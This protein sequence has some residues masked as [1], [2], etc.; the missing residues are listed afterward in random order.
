VNDIC[1]HPETITRTYL[2]SDRGIGSEIVCKICGAVLDEGFNEKD[3]IKLPIVV[4]DS[5]QNGVE[6]TGKNGDAKGVIVKDES[7]SVKKGNKSFDT[8]NRPPEQIVEK[9]KIKTPA[10]AGFL[11]AK[12]EMSY[13][14]WQR[15][16]DYVSKREIEGAKGFTC[17]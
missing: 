9:L 10:Q 4:M 5:K 2:D 7:P 8:R 12:G 11:R 16:R 13:K 1:G 17:H 3:K 15:V 14:E 6:P